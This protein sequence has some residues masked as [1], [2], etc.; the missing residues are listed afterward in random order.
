MSRMHCQIRDALVPANDRKDCSYCLY[1]RNGRG[2]LVVRSALLE[3]LAKLGSD[4]RRLSST[5]V[6]RNFV[7]LDG[8]GFGRSCMDCLVCSASLRGLS[9][10]RESPVNPDIELHSF[11]HSG[12]A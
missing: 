8:K 2:L 9:H 1:C 4:Y 11:A 12:S 6:A 5:P 10:R 7:A 3:I